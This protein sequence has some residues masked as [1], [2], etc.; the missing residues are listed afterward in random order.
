[1]PTGITHA[2]VGWA[3]AKLAAPRDV[4]RKLFVIAPLCAF[5]PDLDTLGFHFGVRYGD[6]IGHRGLTHS[7]PFALVLTL[8]VMLLFFREYKPFVSR[9][10]WGLW[11]MLFSVT[12]V[13]GLLDAMTTGGLGVA[14]FAPFSDTRYFLPWRPIRVSPIGIGGFLHYRRMAAAAVLSEL[15][16]VW[17]PLAAVLALHKWATRPTAVGE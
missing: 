4:P 15:L 10:W 17:L 11:A 13:H 6:L 8:A 9:R 1:M 2:F 7:L 12:A 5:V 3:G 14:F 16:V